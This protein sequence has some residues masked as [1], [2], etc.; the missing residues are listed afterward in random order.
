MQKGK[1]N[2]GGYCFT[3]GSSAILQLVLVWSNQVQLLLQS[4]KLKDDRCSYFI[5]RSVLFL[6]VIFNDAVIMMLMSF[7]VEYQLVVLHTNL[8]QGHPELLSSDSQ[9]GLAL[10]PN[11]QKLFTIFQSILLSFVTFV[12]NN[13]SVFNHFNHLFTRFKTL[14]KPLRETPNFSLSCARA[15]ERADKRFGR[16]WTLSWFFPF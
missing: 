6:S 3:T 2:K 9:R 10:A 4:V 13:N 11:V 5:T 12:L 16:V 8:T 7:Q 14:A 15:R 1:D